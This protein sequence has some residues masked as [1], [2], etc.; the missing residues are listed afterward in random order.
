M[1]QKILKEQIELDMLLAIHKGETLQEYL[2]NITKIVHDLQEKY[3]T[4]DIIDHKLKN[5]WYGY[6]GAFSTYLLLFRLETDEEY[7][8]RLEAERI[9]QEKAD[10]KRLKTL[11]TKRAKAAAAE[12]AERAEFE[13]LKAKYGD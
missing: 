9:K 3:I 4:A 8:K 11:E 10:R 12:E 5:E 2:V 7:S 1:K 6:D 13:R